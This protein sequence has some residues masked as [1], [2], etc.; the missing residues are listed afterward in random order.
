M[1][2]STP[3]PFVA[4]VEL[5][6]EKKLNSFTEAMFHELGAVFEK[7]SQNPDVRAVILTAAGERAFTSGLDVAAASE[8]LIGGGDGSEADSSQDVARKAFALRRHILELQHSI[9]QIEKCAK[10]VICVLFGISYG[11]AIDIAASCDIRVAAQGTRFAVKEVDIG[12]AADLGT[13][14][15]LPHCN[16][17]MSWVKDVCLT[18]RDFDANEALRVGFVSGV[19]DTKATALQ[20]AQDLAKLIAAKSP[21][22]V[23]TTKAVVNY[24]RDHSILDGLDQISL[25]NAAMLQTSDLKSALMAGL[26]R[27][28]PT[29]EKL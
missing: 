10:P 28:T 22:A 12:L 9:T 16:V 20:R 11:A 13:L 18:A 1:R 4:Q 29:F 17:P 14:T 19:F 8:G 27:R 25:W 2:V 5:S 23:Q 6:R 26:Q 24:S 3:Q 7:L 15:R 21:V